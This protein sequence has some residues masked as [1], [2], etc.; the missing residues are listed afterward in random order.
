MQTPGE[1]DDTLFQVIAA[2]TIQI[3]KPS[4]VMET[5]RSDADTL[6][7]SKSVLL[8]I[9]AETVGGDG[10]SGGEESEAA[11]PLPTPAF[12]YAFTLLQHAV[13]KSLADE[14]LVQRGCGVVSEHAQLRGL[15]V[16]ESVAEPDDLHPKYLPRAEMLK[17]M[18][19]V[20]GGT[21]GRTQQTAVAS[22]VEVA[23]SASGGTGK[24]YRASRGSWFGLLNLGYPA[25]GQCVVLCKSNV[26]WSR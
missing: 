25:S 16:G 8:K 11:C 3:L 5:V 9:W 2:V 18:I 6:E 14:E 23:L 21:S 19:D 7:S 17:F 13:R 26:Q 12:S 4:F 1:D 22:L 20:I 10:G 24:Y 15:D